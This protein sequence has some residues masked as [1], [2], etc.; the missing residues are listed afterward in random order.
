MG[1]VLCAN[2]LRHY[3]N[4]IWKTIIHHDFNALRDASH[5]GRAP[6]WWHIVSRTLFDKYPLMAVES[7]FGGLAIYKAHAY[8]KCRY[9]EVTNDCEHVDF[10]RCMRESG[11]EGRI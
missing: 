9:D 3:K 4:I 8:T 2:S 11:S 7:C 10:H 1:D 6:E 5:N